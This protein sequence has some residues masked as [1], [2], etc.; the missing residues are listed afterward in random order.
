MRDDIFHAI[1]TV[2]DLLALATCLGALGCRLW[3]LPAMSTASEAIGF[4]AFLASLWQLLGACLATLVVSSVGELAGRAVEMSDRPLAA[5]FPVLPTIL[6]QTHYGRLWL[7]RPLSLTVLW[8]G[9]WAGRTR[10]RSWI[11]PA[12]MLG[13]GAMVAMTRSA[14]GHAADWGDLTLPALNDWLHLLAASLWGGGLLALSLV[15]LPTAIKLPELRRPLIAAIARRFSVL[16]GVALAGVLL[17]GIYNAWLQ[18]GTISALWETPYGRTLLAKLFLVFPL[19][20][21]GASNRYISVPLLQRWA[22]L[23][24]AKRRFPHA[25]LIIRYL[26]TGR[27]KPPGAHVVRQF[28]RTT[29]A[30][31]ICIIGVFICTALLLHGVPARHGS[32]RAHMHTEAGPSPA[33]SGEA[34]P[35]PHAHVGA[36]PH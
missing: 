23:P 18:V 30:E 16:A 10:L 17:T 31:A 24:M 9:W 22:G 27:R 26:V 36:P 7:V 32:H 5:T 4:D 13:T 34:M 3:V 1:P 25:S 6:L 33:A 12:G 8:I 28:R 15:V 20:A 21:L 35:T 2:F 19:L 14:S 11:I 29:W